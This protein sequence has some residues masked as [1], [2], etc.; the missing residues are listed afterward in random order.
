MVDFESLGWRHSGL[1]VGLGILVF[2]V[3]GVYLLE[4]GMLRRGWGRVALHFGVINDTA[5]R[6][7]ILFLGVSSRV[8][9]LYLALI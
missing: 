8:I 4:V 2:F 5:L 3:V 7:V 9:N 6:E 1:K